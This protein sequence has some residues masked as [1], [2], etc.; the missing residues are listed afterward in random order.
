MSRTVGKDSIQKFKRKN[1]QKEQTFK[2]SNL[3][4]KEVVVEYTKEQ[5]ESLDIIVETL[6]EC[7]LE[8]KNLINSGTTPRNVKEIKLFVAK[9]KIAETISLLTGEP[10]TLGAI[11]R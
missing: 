7:K 10:F 8:I 3:Q 9:S 6:E 4:K 1:V 11:K 2:R 5:Q